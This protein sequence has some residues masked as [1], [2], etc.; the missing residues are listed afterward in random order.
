VKHKLYYDEQNKVLV[1]EV[2]EEFTFEDAQDALKIIRDT[3]ADKAPY[4]ILVDLEKASANL[5][6]DTRKLLQDEAG[7]VGIA[8]MAM[9]VTNPMMRMTGKI[10]AAAMGK[11]NET[12]FFKTRADALAWLKGDAS[13][14]S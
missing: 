5:D 10:M 12:G 13:N 6:R 9:I 2:S 14:D 8:Q 1:M 4:P 11:K 7:N 3:Y